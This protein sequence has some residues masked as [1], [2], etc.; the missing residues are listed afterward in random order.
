MPPYLEVQHEAFLNAVKAHRVRIEREDP[1]DD[2]YTEIEIDTAFFGVGYALTSF[3]S[4]YDVYGKFMAGID[5]RA[6]Y[7]ELEE[8]T[9]NAPG[10]TRAV[11]Q[12]AELLRDE[13]D[14]T[15]NP[16]FHK[17]RE[18]ICSVMAGS[19]Y[20]GDEVIRAKKDLCVD[21]VEKQLRF[22]GHVLAI[23]RWQH[24]LDWNTTV[25]KTHYALVQ[26]YLANKMDVEETKYVT[27]AAQQLLK[28]DMLDIERAALG[29][30]QGAISEAGESTTKTDGKNKWAN[31]L[32]SA[33]SL[34]AMAA[35]AYS[36]IVG[37][38]AG[39]IMSL[40]KGSSGAAAGSSGGSG[41]SFPT[42]ISV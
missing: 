24:H 28:L 17:G 21:L 23:S 8:S 42:Q 22:S 4:L 2:G 5:A 35:S 30:M 32:G 1:Y 6:L 13:I 37:N 29:T 11:V 34:G 41:G 16:E 10:I 3:P 26:S 25:V 12:H 7:E 27:L 40:F 9:V 38:S 33:M 36:A 14:D 15:I 19:Y 20:N 31:Y 39:G 18:D